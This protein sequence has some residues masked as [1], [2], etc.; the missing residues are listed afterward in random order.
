MALIPTA[1][2]RLPTFGGEVEVQ[3]Q[4]E[5]TSRTYAVNWHTGRIG[6]FIDGL[7]AVRQ[8]VYKLLLTERFCHLIYSWNYGVEMSLLIGKS[9]EVLHSEAERILSEAL[10]QDS[11]ITGISNFDIERISRNTAQIKFTVATVYGA[12]DIEQEV[13]I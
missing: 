6:G 2:Q 3:S 12:T 5:E 9:E 10:L 8:A 11:R 1:A 4:A 13:D 7:E